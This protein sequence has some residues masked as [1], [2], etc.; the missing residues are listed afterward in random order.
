MA[1]GWANVL[2]GLAARSVGC[3]SKPAVASSTQK[4]LFI[5]SIQ[6][7]HSAHSIYSKSIA[8]LSWFKFTVIMFV[9][10][11]SKSFSQHT[12]MRFVIFFLVFSTNVFV[13]LLLDSTRFLN[14]FIIISNR[15]FTNCSEVILKI[16]D[17]NKRYKGKQLIWWR[18]A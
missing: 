8:L 17:K 14:C 12:L 1:S 11:V 10:V 5:Y 18:S 6:F 13:F 3:R 7:I 15:V 16:D 9:S 2:L 4:I